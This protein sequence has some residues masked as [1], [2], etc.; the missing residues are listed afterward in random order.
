MIPVAEI[1][2]HPYV[3]KFHSKRRQLELLAGFGSWVV[4]PGKLIRVVLWKATKY[5]RK[6][7]FK[8]QD[9]V[10]TEAPGSSISSNLV[11]V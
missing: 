3:S 9:Q 10:V 11:N 8:V 5:F 6:V 7:N 1:P 4:E 2:S